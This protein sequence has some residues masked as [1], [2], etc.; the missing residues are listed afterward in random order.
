[1]CGREKKGMTVKN[2]EL[3]L[4]VGATPEMQD[5]LLGSFEPI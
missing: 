5:F 1:M 3:R 2:E 4:R